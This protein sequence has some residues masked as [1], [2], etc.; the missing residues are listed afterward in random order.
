[1]TI[2]FRKIYFQNLRINTAR[3]VNSTE[4]SEETESTEEEGGSD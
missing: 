2:A 4:S 1:M 3:L